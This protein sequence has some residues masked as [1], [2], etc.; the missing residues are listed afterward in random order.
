MKK[1]KPHEGTDDIKR[2]RKSCT[3]HSNPHEGTEM[4][5]NQLDRHGLI[6]I[7]RKGTDDFKFA[8]FDPPY[9]CNP[10]EGT[11]DSPLCANPY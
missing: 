10:H 2:C 5:K 9:M 7:P 4:H 1:R 6:K 8:I 3:L 11:D